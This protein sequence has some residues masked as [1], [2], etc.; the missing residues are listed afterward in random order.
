GNGSGG[1]GG[2]PDDDTI[3]V[4]VVQGQDRQIGIAVDDLRGSQD[5]VIK[6]LEDELVDAR[7][8]AG[9]SILGDGTVTLILDVPEIE[10]IAV[11][12]EHYVRKRRNETM[13]RL[14][15][16]LE[17]GRAAGDDSPN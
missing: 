5:I 4:V 9:A 7:G 3:Y 16:Y 2:E 13:R 1:N 8:I 14:E 6:S 11:D 10:K 12:P 17:H 15:Q